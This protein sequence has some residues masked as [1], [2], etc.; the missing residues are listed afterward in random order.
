M[1]HTFIGGMKLVNGLVVNEAKVLHYL[2]HLLYNMFFDPNADGEDQKK[3]KNK[4]F[5]TD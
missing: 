5:T 4:V 3:K 2:A 1:L